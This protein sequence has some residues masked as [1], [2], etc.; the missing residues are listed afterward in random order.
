M[1][2]KKLNSE[3]EVSLSITDYIIDWGHV[4]SKPQKLV[5]DFLYPFWKNQVILEEVKIPGTLLRIDLFNA[6]ANPHIAIEV[7]PEATHRK[8]NKHF[9][10]GS[11]FNFLATMKRDMDKQKWCEQ[12][13]FKFVEIYDADLE[14]LSTTWFFQKYKI[15]L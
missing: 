1:K 7:S 3:R 14:T 10:K 9:H 13:G 11:V 4:V 2:V 5:K 15:V 8:Y 6:T 12:N